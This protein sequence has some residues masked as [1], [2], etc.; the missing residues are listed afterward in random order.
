MLSNLDF[1]QLLGGLGLFLFSMEQIESSL[2]QLGSKSFKNFLLKN[3][4]TPLRSV[5]SGGLSTALLQSSS[6][7]GLLVLA[8]TGAGL[9]TLNNALGVIFGSNLG[10]TLTGWIVAT[11]GFKLDLQSLS[12]PLIALGSLVTISAKGQRKQTGRIVTS[13]GLLLL[14]LEFMK[15]SVGGISEQIDI[16]SMTQFS[17]LQFLIFATFFTAIVQSSSATM[18]LALA[19]LNAGVITLPSAA[20]IAIG[21]DLGTSSTIILGSI[22]GTPNK[23]RVALAHVIFNVTVDLLAFIFLY[24]LIKLI[25]LFGIVNPLYALVAFHSIINLFGVILFLPLIRPLAKFLSGLYK[26]KKPVHSL[27]ISEIAPNVSEAGVIAI[28]KETAHLIQRVILQNSYG[29]DPSISIPETTSPVDMQDNI[30]ASE[31][32]DFMR[33]YDNSKLL[34]G[35]ILTFATDLQLLS[36]NPEESTQLNQLLSAIRYAMHSSKYIKDI[37]A[38]LVNFSLSNK[39]SIKSYSQAVNKMM[40]DFYSQLYLLKNNETE[41]ELTKK[42]TDLSSNIHLWHDQLHKNILEAIQKRAIVETEGSSLLNVNREILNSNLSLI[43]AL[44]NY[45]D[46][47]NLSETTSNNF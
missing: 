9:M 5:F 23:K 26:T 46:T 24:Q 44:S 20:A 40:T 10:T 42:L 35:E 36:L 12:L 1:W 4:N 16:S 34:E 32:S 25:A 22:A 2:S 8:F 7:V 30:L 21:A 28:H 17:I 18:I 39:N 31:L 29:F 37:Q 19:A 3:T 11:I 13:I 45:L 47:E 41:S 33:S 27:Y 6:L 14:G 15:S 38:N 43:T